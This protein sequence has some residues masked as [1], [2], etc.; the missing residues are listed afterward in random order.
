MFVTLFSDEPGFIYLHTVILNQVLLFIVCTQ[1]NGFKYCYLTQ[2]CL[3][4]IILS[5]RLNSSI[6]SIDGT[7]TPYSSNSE[8]T[9]LQSDVV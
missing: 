6:W 1:I 7:L 9:V 2:V 5:K 8:T 4:A 3:I